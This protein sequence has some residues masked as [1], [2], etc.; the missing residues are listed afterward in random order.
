MRLGIDD[1]NEEKSYGGRTLLR[2]TPRG[3]VTVDLAAFLNRTR[4][5]TA[6]WILEAGEYQSN[7]AARQ[8]LRDDLDLYSVTANWDLQGMTATGIV[9]FLKRDFSNVVDVS[10]FATLIRNPVFCA[11]IINGGA[12]C[13]PDQLA[14]FFALVDSQSTTALFPQQDMDTTTAE[15]R[16]SS[17]DGRALHWTAGLFF[18]D[19]ETDVANPQVIVDPITGNIIQPLQV[20]TVR[21][22][23]DELKQ[24]A[25]FGELSWDATSRLNLTA[26]TRYYRYTK[27]IVG[28]TPIGSILV[29]AVVTP[30]TSVSSDE[31][32]WVSKLN[33][34][35]KISDGVMVYAQ[36]AEGFRPGGAN[37]VVG[38][39]Q[40]LTPYQSDDLI[41][42][43]IGLKS[44]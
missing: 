6:S 12:A 36:A 23:N 42:Y 21:F 10:G 13:G 35:Y 30:P 44:A 18:S 1:I 4:T 29:G 39:P 2:W 7:A 31:N 9:S 43:E 34:S 38:L 41:N 11:R 25:G 33:A 37:Q 5:D 32:G 22:I 8:P 19:R 3:N 14:S 15:L 16:L 27:D 28:Q 17:A 24:S 40:P 26:G 20:A